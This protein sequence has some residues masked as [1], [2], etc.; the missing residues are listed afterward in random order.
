[1]RRRFVL[2]TF[3]SVCAG[4]FVAHVT[5][6]VA[7]PSDPP[8]SIAIAIDA[9]T[10][11]TDDVLQGASI[12][13]SPGGARLY[14]ADEPNQSIFVLSTVSVGAVDAIPS[15]RIALTGAPAQI[16]A[17]GD[18][19]LVTQRN[20]G[21]LVVFHADEQKGL[22]ED[23]RVA[24]AADAW[25]VAV[26]PDHSTAIVTSAWTHTVSAID[27][28]TSTV[29]WSVEVA[30]E[31]R[32]VAIRP[33]GKE[34]YVS[35][36]T[37]PDLTT[38]ENLD[39]QTPF[40]RTATLPVAPLVANN[41][42]LTS[43]L[44]WSLALSSDGTRLFAPRRALGGGM[45]EWNGA[46]TVDVLQANV[47][48]A[49]VEAGTFDVVGMPTKNGEVPNET[50]LPSTHA[51]ATEVDATLGAMTGV[52]VPRAAIVREKAHS[53]L[54]ASEGS[55]RLY[56]L[57]ARSLAPATQKLRDYDL[58]QCSG[59]DG[60]ALSLDG[61]IAYVHC[62]AS[63]DVRRVPLRGAMQDDTQSGFTF[64]PTTYAR[65]VYAT[66]PLG[67]LAAMG[68]KLF[69]DGV[70]LDVSGGYPC[71]GCHPDG[72]DDGHVWAL[73]TTT[74][75]DPSP[76]GGNDLQSTVLASGAGLADSHSFPRQTP[77]LA[78][79]VAGKGPYGWN[80]EAPTLA[81]RVEEGMLLHRWLFQRGPVDPTPPAVHDKAVA[82]AAFLRLGL[83]PPPRTAAPLDAIAAKGKEL[84]EGRAR[85]S[86]C[87]ATGDA[88]SPGDPYHVKGIGEEARF[89]FEAETGE[90]FKVP[91]L[92]FVEGT[93]PYYHDGSAP[94][95]EAL[96]DDDHDRMGKTVDLNDEERTALV[97]YLRTL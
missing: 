32:A 24:L 51:V 89:D 12:V 9:P 20:P 87:H 43:T 86:T 75:V 58:G 93:A 15:A 92:H 36:L 21:A 85:C 8:P 29:R 84:F 64:E 11:A 52:I 57:D 78:G 59:P 83:V 70:D 48:R 18:H 5:T 22:V 37:S 31:P 95:L 69:V 6:G 65:S 40:V 68:R 30:R 50:A 42:Y 63:F 28:P 61:S 38:I 3:V 4:A 81:A 41:L 67:P 46:F 23:R 74:A 26:T 66:D 49:L 80:A 25:G 35:H 16:V 2:A 13:R 19:V 39:D 54:V 79:R 47:D 34:V 27:L 33:D 60:V 14:V 90:T 17:Y 77:M 62:A 53:L 97:A 96:V 91:N 55:N 76:Y 82:L 45:K 94:T 7:A 72:R 88:T 44:G 56:E 73:M 71:S 1:M 10:A